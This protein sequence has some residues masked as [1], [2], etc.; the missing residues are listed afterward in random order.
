MRQTN[1]HLVGRTLE[2]RQSSGTRHQNTKWT[3]APVNIGK[4]RFPEL[5]LRQAPELMEAMERL[6]PG[7]EFREERTVSHYR[8][9]YSTCFFS[10]V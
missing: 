1:G 3:V 9:N 5:R 2:Q 4:V 10:M 7:W 6:Y 8:D